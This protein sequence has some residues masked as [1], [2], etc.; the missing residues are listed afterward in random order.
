MKKEKLIERLITKEYGYLLEVLMNYAD[1]R[2]GTNEA[3]LCITATI[4]K[5]IEKYDKKN[6]K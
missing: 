1:K 5:I 4:N 6:I 2:I 3:M